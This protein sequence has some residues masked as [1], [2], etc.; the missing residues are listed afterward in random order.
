M[1]IA[2][3]IVHSD[4]SYG[5]RDGKRLAFHHYGPLSADG[6]AILF[7]NSGGFESG[8]AILHTLYYQHQLAN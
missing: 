4:L 7:V 5:E 8:T 2:S 3:A 1:S 6:A